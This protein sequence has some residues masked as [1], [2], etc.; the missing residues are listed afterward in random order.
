MGRSSG[1]GWHEGEPTEQG[2]AFRQIGPVKLAV[3]TVVNATGVVVDRA[4]NVVRGNLNR[5]TGRRRTY[6]EIAE[7]D[8]SKR[9]SR[10]PKLGNTTLTLVLT[11]LKMSSHVLSQL[12]R[13]VHTS[14]SRAIQPFHG[15][16][17]G[18]V[19]YAATFNQVEDELDGMTLGVLGSDLAWDAVLAA[20]T[21]TANP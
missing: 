6:A 12:G 17:D 10:E 3:F 9:E 18:D 5:E 4:G 19:L 13:Q 1:C 15:P 8:I 16:Y 11:N 7:I 2:G 21:T 20:A 14:M